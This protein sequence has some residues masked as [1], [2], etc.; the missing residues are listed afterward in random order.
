[1]AASYQGKRVR[2]V[3]LGGHGARF[4]DLILHKH[5]FLGSPGHSQGRSEQCCYVPQ[6]TRP[7]MDIV[8]LSKSEQRSGKV[9]LCVAVP[10]LPRPTW[11]TPPEVI[12]RPGCFSATPTSV[13]AGLPNASAPKLI[14]YTQ[15]S[16]H[17]M[18]VD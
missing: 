1:M 3:R 16:T 18:L 11:A 6:I 2:Q 9:N 8:V 10:F 13:R 15:L 5:F 17:P 14:T 7:G 12:E 4:P